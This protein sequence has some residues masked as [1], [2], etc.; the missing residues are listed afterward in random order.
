MPGLDLNLNL[1]ERD[2]NSFL[3][4]GYNNPIFIRKFMTVNWQRS[5]T[6]HIF[7]NFAYKCP[8]I[9]NFSFPSFVRMN[10]NCAGSESKPGLSL[11][12]RITS[13]EYGH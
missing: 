13:F 9:A 3:C 5:Q 12:P 2:S 1:S 4:Y 7:N 6:Q 10:L 11:R 8:K